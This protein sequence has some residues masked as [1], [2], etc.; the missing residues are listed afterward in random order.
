MAELHALSSPHKPNYHGVEALSSPH[1]PTY[2]GVEGKSIKHAAIKH[3]GKGVLDLKAPLDYCEAPT[4]SCE[5][6]NF[7][8]SG[9]TEPF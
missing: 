7:C 1:K 5:N 4:R 9:Q 8:S 6:L 3:A 2:H